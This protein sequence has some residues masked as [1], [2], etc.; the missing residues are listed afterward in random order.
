MSRPIGMP[1]D[2]HPAAMLM[3]WDAQAGQYVL[4]DLGEPRCVARWK[5]D[6]F[7]LSYGWHSQGDLCWR[8]APHRVGDAWFCDW[9]FKIALEW[10][11]ERQQAEIAE[12][13]REKMRLARERSAETRRLNIERLKAEEEAAAALSVVYYVQ[14]ESDGLIKIGTT[15]RLGSRMAAIRSEHGPVELLLTH[16][17]AHKREQ[18]I[19]DL[20]AEFRAEGEWFQPDPQLRQWIRDLRDRSYAINDK[21]KTF[22]ER[23]RRAYLRGLIDEQ[24]S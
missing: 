1:D 14:R 8:P 20:F 23:M 9:H 18:E 4:A 6:G 7:A 5:F 11:R 13:H 10:R 17:G 19:H 22:P 21:L 2:Y 24:A 16:S 15:R 3:V 12:D